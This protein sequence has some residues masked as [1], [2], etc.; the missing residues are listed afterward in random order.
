MNLTIH[1]GTNEI[2]GSC[3]EIATVNT[4]LL[5]DIGL[6]LDSIVKKPE[7]LKQYL[8]KIEGHIDAVFISHYHLD[9]SW[10]GL[11]N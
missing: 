4:R 2:G 8:P 6:P 10:L 11:R 7:D 1:R 5:I 3:V 9:L